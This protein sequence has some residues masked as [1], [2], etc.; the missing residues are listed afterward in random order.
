M[1]LGLEFDWS[2]GTW[3]WFFVVVLLGPLYGVIIGTGEGYLGRWSLALTLWSQL[4]FPNPW[5]ELP[6]TL[7]GASIGL[8]F[9]SD[10]VWGVVTSCVPQTGSLIRTKMNSIRYFQ[11]MEFLILSLSPNWLIPTSGGSW[12]SAELSSTVSIPFTLG[13]GE[14][15]YILT[16][17][18]SSWVNLLVTFVGWDSPSLG[19]RVNLL[20]NSYE[21]GI[22]DKPVGLCL[23]SELGSPLGDLLDYE[24]WTN[25]GLQ[26]IVNIPPGLKVRYPFFV[27]STSWATLAVPTLVY[28]LKFP[29]P[30]Y[31]TCIILNMGLELTNTPVFP[32]VFPRRFWYIANFA[33]PLKVNPTFFLNTKYFHQH[34]HC[35]FDNLTVCTCCVW[36]INMEESMIQP[37]TIVIGVND[38]SQ[39][40]NSN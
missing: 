4:E 22:A 27:V 36:H 40:L 37:F 13:I 33:P 35:I 2:F 31:G 21:V 39:L 8:W 29:P 38:D 14:D 19:A 26:L 34:I 9:G 18:L 24:N 1:F 30:P 20:K 5:A 3:E 11:L 25:L 15:S 32:T 17:E 6:G 12:R 23:V 10:V 7:L 28:C 16:A